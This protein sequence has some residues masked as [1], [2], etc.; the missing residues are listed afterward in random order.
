MGSDKAIGKIRF[1]PRAGLEFRTDGGRFQ[2]SST[3]DFSSNVVD[4]YTIGTTSSGWNETTNIA[5]GTAF[6]YVRYLAPN[7]SYG[8]VAEIEFYG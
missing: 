5:S 6:R 1:S 4:L 3:A 8:N 7:G 2:G